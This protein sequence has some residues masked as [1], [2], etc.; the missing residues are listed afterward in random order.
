MNRFKI[1]TKSKLK[2]LND[3]SYIT[4]LDLDNNNKKKLARSN[5]LTPSPTLFKLSIYYNYSLI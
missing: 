4:F 1:M 2:L 3:L 5:D